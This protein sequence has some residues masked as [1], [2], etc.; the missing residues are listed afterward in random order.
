MKRNSIR[1]ALFVL[2]I[3]LFLALPGQTSCDS[4]RTGKHDTIQVVDTLKVS[5]FRIDSVII[6]KV[7]NDDS[8]FFNTYV[9]FSVNSDTLKYNLVHVSTLYSDGWDTLPQPL[10]W[11]KIINLEPDTALATIAKNRQIIEGIYSANYDSLT[12]SEKTA[13]K[14]SLRNLQKLD[15]DEKVYVT[16]GRRN[17]YELEQVIPQI[18]SAIKIFIENGTD[19]FY[20]QAVIAIE[21]PNRLEYSW[22]GAYGP[23]QLMKGIGLKYGLLINDT[24]DERA[25]LEKSAKVTA[26][27][28]QDF[29][30][31]MVKALL[32][33][34]K[35]AF[36]ESD[37]WFK[38]L[39]LH[40]Y[41]AGY[42]NVR[43]VINKINPKEGGRHIIQDMWQTEYS[44]FKN[45]SQNYSQVAL[46]ALIQL[47]SLIFRHVKKKEIDTLKAINPSKS[48]QKEL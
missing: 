30:I 16:F 41:H 44:S 29:C 42:G 12:R 13:Y 32:K 48:K 3:S 19:P 47:D 10:F 35:I 8:I 18:D 24:I 15:E 25:D 9:E 40:T 21:S 1:I 43:G 14:D 2:N 4:A 27:Y 31:P 33:S 11:N 22:A 39:V 7:Y 46:A 23:F 6:H 36:K 38:L 45:A 5:G 34:K 28:F 26:K 37:L 20:A 17:L